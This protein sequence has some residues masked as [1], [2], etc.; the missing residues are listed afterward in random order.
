[1]IRETVCQQLLI[2]DKTQLGHCSLLFA[3]DEL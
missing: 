1:L 2:S 3:V